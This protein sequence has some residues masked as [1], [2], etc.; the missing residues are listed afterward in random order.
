MKIVSYNVNGIR[1]AIKKGF[2]DWLENSD[3]DILCLQET[4]AKKSQIPVD[5]IRDIGYHTY[6]THGVKAGY[7]GVAVLTKWVPKHIEYQ[8]DVDYIDAEGRIIRTDFEDFSLLSVYVNSIPSAPSRYIQLKDPFLWEQELSRY[9]DR[10]KYK[11]RFML[12]FQNYLEILKRQQPN[13][14]VCGDF[15]VCHH[16]IDIHQANQ[17]KT[18]LSGFLPQ[19]RKWFNSLIESGLIDTFRYKNPLEEK[20]TWWSF[21]ANSRTKNLGWRID[22][23]LATNSLKTSITDSFILNDVV[24]SDHCPTGVTL[25]SSA[26]HRLRERHHQEISI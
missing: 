8:C 6:L 9:K 15:N 21:R 19:E 7:S 24:H 14:V 2:L 5:T 11:E 18:N 17:K 3:I 25:D 20:Y 13:L 23:V 1:S 12:S 4:R 16:P 10:L 22:Y 26:F